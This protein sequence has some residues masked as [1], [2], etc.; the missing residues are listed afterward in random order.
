M[1]T[2]AK[3]R[4]TQLQ[5]Q[6]VAYIVADLESVSVQD[7]GSNSVKTS[8]KF[9]TNG[10]FLDRSTGV[11]YGIACGSK[12][13]AVRSG[14]TQHAKGY[15]RGT[16][17]CFNTPGGTR[18][19]SVPIINAIKD[20]AY[21]LD[22][23]NWA[24]GGMSLHVDRSSFDKDENAFTKEVVSVEN[25]NGINGVSPAYKA[26]RTA[27]GFKKSTN[28]IILIQAASA[29]PFEMRSILKSLGADYGVMLD[30]SDLSQMRGKKADG[31]VVDAN[32]ESTKVWH[33]V[34]VQP[35]SW[36]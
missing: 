22:W 33:M 12:G 27:I 24:I 16:M 35:T 14:G 19:I 23:I 28:E 4:T 6:T 25:A 26:K 10:T 9:G 8:G 34:T 2:T 18:S 17:V 29:T 11:V 21:P 36:A 13:V 30:G 20:A 31:T 32:T 3:Y 1:A 15:K 7:V 5:G